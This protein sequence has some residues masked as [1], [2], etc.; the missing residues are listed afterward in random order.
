MRK[1]KKHRRVGSKKCKTIKNTE[2]K[3]RDHEAIAKNVSGNVFVSPLRLAFICV[4]A[5]SK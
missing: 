3:Q 4:R 2:K 5:M 1:K